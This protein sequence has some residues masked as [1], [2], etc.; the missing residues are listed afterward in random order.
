[1]GKKQD[2]QGSTEGKTV[3]QKKLKKQVAEKEEKIV[4]EE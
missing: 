4:E 3:K 1:M 2:T